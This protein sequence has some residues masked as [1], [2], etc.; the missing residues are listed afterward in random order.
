[1]GPSCGSLNQA[2]QT[3]SRRAGC[4]ARPR[5]STSQLLA[6]ELGDGARPQAQLHGV[7]PGHAVVGST[8]SS[9]AIMRCTYSSSRSRAH[10]CAWA[11][12]PGRAQVQMAHL[13]IVGDADLGSSAAAVFGRVNSF[14]I[15]PKAA[16]GLAPGRQFSVKAPRC[17]RRAGGRQAQ[18]GDR[19]PPAPDWRTAAA[20][21][22]PPRHCGRWRPA[23]RLRPQAGK[24]VHPG[25]ADA[26]IQAALAFAGGVHVPRPRPRASSQS[27]SA[28]R[29]GRDRAAGAAATGPPE[30]ARTGCA[31]GC[32][33]AAPR[34]RPR[35]EAAQHQHARARATTGAGRQGG[36]RTWRL[37]LNLLYFN[38]CLR[39]IYKRQRPKCLNITPA[40]TPAAAGAAQA[41]SRVG[42]QLSP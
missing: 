23:G 26:G 35:Q 32:S 28:R 8:N 29:N 17:I 2:R 15:N 5:C 21:R 14:V 9:Q 37:P 6:A 41:L 3:A 31:H 38:G 25:I 40:G 20:W 7:A 19:R 13:A 27:R 24:V 18:P 1:M 10:L 11:L 33:T 22:K 4:S 16:K 36:Q 34:A 39:L 30:W 12:Y 42:G